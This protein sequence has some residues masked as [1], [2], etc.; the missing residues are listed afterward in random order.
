M[1]RSAMA[2]SVIIDGPNFISRLIDNGLDKDFIAEKFS[3][4]NFL[5]EE[6]RIALKKEF[7]ADSALG[8]EFFY[9]QKIPG[10]TKNKMTNNQWLKF[11]ERESKENAVYL[12]KVEIDSDKEKGVDIAVAVR[13]IEVAEKCTVVCL[14]SSDKDFLPALEY[15]KN[16]GTYICTAGASKLHPIELKN[17]SYFFID[18]THYLEKI[19]RKY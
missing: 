3:L 7:G 17:V 10:P 9:S 4:N 16:K 6:I 18:I 14:V 2:Y 13:L 19:Q 15:L 5:V 8:L 1:M 11:I 12:R